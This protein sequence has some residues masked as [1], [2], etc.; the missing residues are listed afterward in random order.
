MVSGT[1][2]EFVYRLDVA[3]IAKVAELFLPGSPGRKGRFAVLA[4]SPVSCYNPRR[5]S[6]SWGGLGRFLLLSFTGRFFIDSFS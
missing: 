1:S 4:I 6:V 5:E 3:A 2:S